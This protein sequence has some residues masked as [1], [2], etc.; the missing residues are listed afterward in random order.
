[1]CVPHNQALPQA[2]EGGQGALAA[3]LMYAAHPL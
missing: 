3:L 1:M 2:G